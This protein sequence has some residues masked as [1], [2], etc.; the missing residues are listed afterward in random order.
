MAAVYCPNVASSTLDNPVNSVGSYTSIAI[1]ADGVPV[2]SYFDSV[3]NDLKVAK[4]GS[5]ACR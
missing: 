5:L 2:I 3:D 1:G 4:C